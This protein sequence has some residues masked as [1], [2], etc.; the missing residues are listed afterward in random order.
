[1]W[2]DPG[3]GGPWT[4]DLKPVGSF[5]WFL[6]VPSYRQLKNLKLHVGP[7]S[8]WL[9]MVFYHIQ[10]QVCISLVSHSLQTHWT[11]M[12]STDTNGSWQYHSRML[13]FL[14][15]YI[16]IFKLIFGRFS[17]FYSQRSV[18]EPGPTLVLGL[19]LYISASV[20]PKTTK[21][22]MQHYFQMEQLEHFPKQARMCNRAPEFSFW[23][24]TDHYCDIERL[25]VGA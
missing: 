17:A 6:F 7:P 1:M 3:I 15:L 14:F 24:P 13:D 2:V 10:S 18:T 9:F 21:S 20:H 16:F 19:F 12:T 11:K 4:W 25:L 23:R 8:N 5:S 22:S